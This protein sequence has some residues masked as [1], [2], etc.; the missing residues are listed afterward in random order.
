MTRLYVS[1]TPRAIGQDFLGRIRC[2]QTL[3]RFKL[4]LFG[5]LEFTLPKVRQIELTFTYDIKCGI[6][7]HITV[8]RVEK[9]LFGIVPPANGED[10]QLIFTQC[11][12]QAFRELALLKNLSAEQIDATESQLITEG[13]VLKIW[14]PKL[15]KS[16]EFYKVQSYIVVRNT[17]WEDFACLYLQIQELK[18]AQTLELLMMQAA[19]SEVLAVCS[20]YIL[21]NDSVVGKPSPG[22]LCDLYRYRGYPLPVKVSLAELFP[23]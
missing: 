14:R 18:S 5:E 13:E 8:D 3:A 4:K 20:D 16:N 10:P 17:R 7:N 19:L 2:E 9:I 22:I 23:A 21:T 6:L 11:L 15:N 1:F 12:A